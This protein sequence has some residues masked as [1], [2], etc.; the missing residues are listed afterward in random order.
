MF[1]AKKK[2]TKKMSHLAKSNA[3][4]F[5]QDDISEQHNLLSATYVDWKWV[6]DR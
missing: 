6:A 5:E 1:L 4:G 2:T 3:L